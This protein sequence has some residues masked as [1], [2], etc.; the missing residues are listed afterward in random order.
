MA[1][2]RPKAELV[3][4][5]DERAQLQSIARSRSMPAA[6]SDASA[7]RAGSA[8]GEANSAI[9]ERLQLTK[10]HGGQVARALHRAPHRRAV[11]RTAARAS[12]AR[13]TTSAWPS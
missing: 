7:H 11:R 5:D 6:L 9:A 4:S 1:M 8:E 3:L 13:S 12:R 2:G 10:R